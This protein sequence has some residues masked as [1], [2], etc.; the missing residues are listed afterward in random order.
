[1]RVTATAF[2]EPTALE[3]VIE[4]GMLVGLP[5]GVPD[6]T[7][8]EEFRVAQAGRVPEVTLQP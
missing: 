1:M 8:V 7:Q 2:E 6:R 5:V 3:A 4:I